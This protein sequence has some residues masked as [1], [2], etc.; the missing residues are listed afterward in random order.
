MAARIEVEAL[1][2][3]EFRVGVID[4]DSESSHR[5]TLNPEHYNR[6]TRGKIEPQERW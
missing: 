4:G 1:S 2:D 5:V 6:L 3:G